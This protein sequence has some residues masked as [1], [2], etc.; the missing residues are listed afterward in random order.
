MLYRR[1]TLVCGFEPKPHGSSITDSLGTTRKDSG[2]GKARNGAGAERSQQGNHP[3]RK[4]DAA[5]GRIKHGL[6]G[7]RE[8]SGRT[9]RGPEGKVGGSGQ[10]SPWRS[11]VDECM[12][13]DRRVEGPWVAFSPPMEEAL[14]SQVDGAT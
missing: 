10:E 14:N 6:A 7:S 1:A 5:Q 8:W 11:P 12:G 2:K 9:G 4:K 3:V 13:V